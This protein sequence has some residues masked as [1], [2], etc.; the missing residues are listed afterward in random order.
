VPQLIEWVQANNISKVGRGEPGDPTIYVEI[1]IGDVVIGR[2]PLD[3]PERASAYANYAVQQMYMGNWEKAAAAGVDVRAAKKALGTDT[4]LAQEG[5]Y[6]RLAEEAPAEP[7]VPTPAVPTQ[8]PAGTPIVTRDDTLRVG[9]AKLGTETNPQKTPSTSNIALRMVSD[10]VLENQINNIKN[11]RETVGYESLPE[12]FFTE[13]DPYKAARI[14]IDWMKDNLKALYHAFPQELRERAARWYEGANRIAFEFADD[15]S[16]DPH[17]AAGVLAVLSPQ[18][19]WYYNVAQAEQLLDVWTNH[20]DT[21]IEGAFAREMEAIIEV[22]QAPQ[23]QLTGKSKIART[24][25]NNKAKRKRRRDMEPMVGQTLAQLHERALAGDEEA[26]IAR[27]WAIRTIAQ[28]IHGRLASVVTPEGDAADTY[29]KLDGNPQTNT[30]GSLGE[31]DKAVSILIDGSMD[32]V[33]EQLGRAHKVRSFYNNIISPNSILGDVTMDT[34]A[35]AA[36]YLL[37][38][39]SSARPVKDNLGTGPGS[40]SVGVKGVYHLGAQAYREAAFDLELLPR[41]LQSIVWEAIRGMYPQEDKV[42][43]FTAEKQETWLGHDEATARAILSGQTIHRPDWAT[44]RDRGEPAA[45]ASDAGTGLG[46]ATVAGRGL[47]YRGGSDRRV[48]RV[49]RSVDA[50]A[51]TRSH[52]RAAAGRVWFEPGRSDRRAQRLRIGDEE[53]DATRIERPNLEP[54][55][56]ITDAA[57]Y[58]Q[59]ISDAKAANK[60]GS[61]VYVY[62]LDDYKKYRLYITETGTA[63]VALTPTGDMVSVFRHPTEPKPEAIPSLIATAVEDGATHADAFDTILPHIYARFG[64]EVVSRMSFNDEFAPPDWDYNLYK[65]YKDGRPNVVFLARTGEVNPYDGKRGGYKTDYDA[66]VGVQQRKIAKVAKQE[67]ALSED[68]DWETTLEPPAQPELDLIYEPTFEQAERSPMSEAEKTLRSLENSISVL[69]NGIAEAWNGQKA[70]S[71]IGAKANTVE[72]LAAAASVYRNPSIEVFRAFFVKDGVVLN[73]VAYSSRLP[74]AIDSVLRTD[75]VAR[76]NQAAEQLD[77]DVYMLH[78]HPSGTPIPSNED[79]TTTLLAYNRIPRLKDHIVIDHTQYATIGKDGSRPVHTFKQAPEAAYDLAKPT[80]P[81]PLL[82][83]QLTPDDVA[84]MAS[85]LQMEDHMDIVGLGGTGEGIK[86]IARLPVELLNQFAEQMKEPGAAGRRAERRLLAHIRRFMRAT[87]S[88]RTVLMNVPQ[89]HAALAIKAIKAGVVMDAHIDGDSATLLQLVPSAKGATPVGPLGARGPAQL[90]EESGYEK[91]LSTEPVVPASKK[92]GLGRHQPRKG[93]AR[94]LI[95]KYKESGKGNKVEMMTQVAS[96]AMEWAIQQGVDKYRAGLRNARLLGD[97]D[98]RTYMMMRLSNTSQSVIEQ[99][100]RHGEVDWDESGHIYPKELDNG[101]MKVFIELGEDLDDW[102]G[103]IIGKRAEKL[104]EEGRENLFTDEDIANLLSLAY[105]G[106]TTENMAGTVADMT[107][108][109]GEKLQRFNEANDR[110]NEIRKS[111]LDYAEHAGIISSQGRHGKVDKETGEI[112]SP[113]WD[114]DFYLP[115]YRV[116]DED[117]VQVRGQRPA[118]DLANLEQMRRLKGGAEELGDP[119]QNILANFHYLITSSQKNL[120]AT[121][122]MKDATKLGFAEPTNEKAGQDTIWILDDGQKEYYKVSDNLTLQTM[123]HVH[124]AGVNHP[125]MGVLRGLKRALTFGVTTSPAY[126][127]ANL[128]RDSIHAIAVSN[129]LGINPFGNVLGGMSA[130]QKDSV[131]YRMLHGSG[132]TMNFGQLFS[133]DPV[134]AREQLNQMLTSEGLTLQ[135]QAD[136]DALGKVVQAAK[137]YLEFGNRVENVQR[138]QIG[139]NVANK[140]LGEGMSI[141]NPDGTENIEAIQAAFKKGALDIAFK[142][143]DV[144]DFHLTG[145]HPVVQY[146]IQTVPFLNARLQ[147]L[148]VLGRRTGSPADM[149]RALKTGSPTADQKR[150]MQVVTTYT[151]ASLLLYLLFKDKEEYDELEEWEKDTYHHFWVGNNHFR[152]PR[153]FEIG[154]I[155]ALAE[156]AASTWVDDAADGEL[157]RQRL[158]FLLQEQLAMGVMPQAFKPGIEIYANQNSFTGRP[159]ESMAMKR[160]LKEERRQPWTPQ[161]AVMMSEMTGSKLSPLQ[162]DHLVQGYTGWL[163]ATVQALGEMAYGVVSDRPDRPAEGVTRLPWGIIDLPPLDRFVKGGQPPRSTKYTTAFYE[164]LEEANQIYETIRQMRKLGRNEEALKLAVQE[165]DKL[166]QRAVMSRTQKQIA[167]INTRIKSIYNDKTMDPLRKREELQNLTI[168][169]NKAT[170]L[171]QKAKK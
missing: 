87:G 122:G 157:F 70:H 127:A 78:N 38:F 22:A 114:D 100:F 152:I 65:R 117:D 108:I 96:T 30:W 71:I 139:V 32:N 80:L 169:K 44:G 171:H 23:K 59:L 118:R 40:P 18:K 136:L 125:G 75:I 151:S 49:A 153:P 47:R 130:S 123:I 90:R 156:R 144:M 9:T 27:N 76:I 88:G 149:W 110:W 24:K 21:L 50:S 4:G 63:G 95:D 10:E 158:M 20:Q 72:D 126:M 79:V 58:H 55:Y 99:L 60:F 15:Y 102:F 107:N 31:I 12:A 120:A 89:E 73:E 109:S 166:A 51:G 168:I 101:I 162:V 46:R 11:R 8:T 94:T 54:V 66:A 6:E 74:G 142:S 41:Q 1:R 77:S 35:K 119:L 133:G 26:Q 85:V 64:F 91:S 92:A 138:I 16:I 86:G 105:D 111:V 121:A 140:M 113:G 115:F 161:T 150:F 112:T 53:L 29:L 134:K 81:H 28:S 147:G 164:Q 97:E 17:Q 61:S 93:V 36:A 98:A 141:Y 13:E 57:L 137:N 52:Y 14:L 82:Q 62:P 5:E 68:F 56:E 143:T 124:H 34:H 106:V 146:L 155:G 159:V 167:K 69:A 145:A 163:G 48:D 33:S 132:G 7:A 135:S 129:D 25:L 154:A 84:F 3:S 104:M 170:K 131:F 165:K 67:A 43:G 42:K 148:Y 19:N 2:T 83:K 116:A 160:L 103:W 45:D 37:P 39:G 128:I